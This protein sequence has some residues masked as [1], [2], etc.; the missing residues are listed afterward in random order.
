MAGL[1]GETAE[2]AGKSAAAALVLFCFARIMGK[3]QISHL[4]FF[5]YT[6]GISIGS[7]AAAFSVDRRIPLHDGIV[8]LAVWAFVPLLFSFLS[9]HSLTARKILD[10]SPIILVQNG[11]IMEKN[12]KKSR[13]T[14]NDLLEELRE[15][16]IFNIA[17]VN[18]AILETNGKLSVLKNDP[19]GQIAQKP[20]ET[21]ANLIIDGKLMD[22]SL[23]WA[24]LDKIRVEE[25]LRGRGVHSIRDVLYANAGENGSLHVDIKNSEPQEFS[26]FQ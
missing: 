10:G 8:S 22:E 13:F 20:P 6:V 15:K 2:I 26:I 5:D 9:I 4:S 12:L 14:V 3:K 18:F 7:I 17:E 1:L 23:K 24:K 11:R 25:E 19:G 16:D 21:Y